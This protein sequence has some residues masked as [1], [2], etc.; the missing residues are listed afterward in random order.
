MAVGEN[1]SEE[2]ENKTVVEKSGM[3]EK[4]ATSKKTCK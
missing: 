4:K 3:T 1:S 2:T